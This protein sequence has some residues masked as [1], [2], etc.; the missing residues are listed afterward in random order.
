[1][2]L[3]SAANSN[4]RR[5]LKSACALLTAKEFMIHRFCHQSKGV[6]IEYPTLKSNIGLAE[7][8][9]LALAYKCYI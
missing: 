5:H 6:F 4:A 7:Y 9:I 3:L 1:M 8:E 2:V